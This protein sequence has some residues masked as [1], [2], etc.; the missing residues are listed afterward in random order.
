MFPLLLPQP[1]LKDFYSIV[2]RFFFN[3][4]VMESHPQFLNIVLCCCQHYC[5][6]LNEHA[7]KI[8]NKR[9]GFQSFFARFW[10]EL[11]L[12]LGYLLSRILYCCFN[13][14]DCFAKV[15][16]LL[17]LC[18]AL[19]PMF[20]NQ[21]FFNPDRELSGRSIERPDD[22]LNM[23]ALTLLAES[24]FQEDLTTTCGLIETSE[25]YEGSSQVTPIFKIS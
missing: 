11:R 24:H 22:N 8:F 12:N 20:R 13:L 19:S 21:R 25:A 2:Y 14:V 10:R 6:L 16:K 15:H 23:M 4:R 3:L 18:L 9:I 5:C 1:L 7:A 17:L